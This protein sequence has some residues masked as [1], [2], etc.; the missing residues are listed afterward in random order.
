MIGKLASQQF[1][2]KCLGSKTLSFDKTVYIN[3]RTPV[4]VTC[5]IHGDMCISPNF[6]ETPECK[7]CQMIK[8][9]G[10]KYH[11]TNEEYK[12]V[13]SSLHNNKY[14]YSKI[15]INDTKISVICPIHGIFKIR[16][17]AHIA[18]SQLYGCQKCG[19]GYSKGEE[20]IE[21]WCKD[22]DIAYEREYIFNGLVSNKNQNQNLP[23]DFYL[24]SKNLV[25]EF[26]GQHHY[27]LIRYSKTQTEQDIIN[28]FE[29]IKTS[30][31]KK[32]QYIL[33]NK[34][35]MLRIRVNFI[36]EVNNI[37]NH[38]ILGLNCDISD[39]PYITEM[40]ENGKVICTLK[41]YA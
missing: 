31:G 15:D 7:L 36:K 41:G 23:F 22:N 14:D 27:K 18:K 20:I 1:N 19:R 30:D 3:I 16:K 28:K 9:T 2:E 13:A 40:I 21:K 33:D 4:I 34:I 38:E 35:N 10:K 25:I 6:K 29:Q 24:P 8:Q 5:G 39:T 11:L 37:L 12:I 32:V 26:D 17:S